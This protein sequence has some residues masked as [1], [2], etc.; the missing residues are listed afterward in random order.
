MSADVILLA[1]DEDDLTANGP[2]ADYEKF[3]V[4][5]VLVRAV[6]SR[7]VRIRDQ[8]DF[9]RAVESFAGSIVGPRMLV[10]GINAVHAIM[11]I[12]SVE[13]G[14]TAEE[15]S[16]LIAETAA[17]LGARAV[18][19]A[20]VNLEGERV[21]AFEGAKGCDTSILDRIYLS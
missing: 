12:R 10:V 11:G 2:A 13:A 7:P 9:R 3:L 1:A 8:E 20:A 19:I 4:R 17:A 15:N 5:T 21:V 16:R 14:L 6:G 18:L